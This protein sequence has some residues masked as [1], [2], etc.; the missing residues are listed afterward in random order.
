MG[1]DYELKC[2]KCGGIIEHDDTF[3][4]ED[5]E[6]Y[7]VYSCAGHCTTCQANFHWQEYKIRF[8][9]FTNFEEVF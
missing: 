7:V 6:N 2:P 1:L 4:S 5:G 8:S 3:D 9:V